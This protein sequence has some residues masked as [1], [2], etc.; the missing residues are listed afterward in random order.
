MK[1]VYLPI[2]LL[3]IGILEA[4]FCLGC[5]A[6]SYFLAD[7][8]VASLFFILFSF[9]GFFCIFGYLNCRITYDETS[10]TAKNIFGIKR[11]YQYTEITGISG[12]IKDIHFYMGKRKVLIDGIAVGSAEFVKF[13]KKRYRVL[14]DGEAIPNQKRKRK[15][16]IFNGNIE[17]PGEFILIYILVSVLD[18]VLLIVFSVWLFAP[19]NAE[20]TTHQEVSFVSYE[21]IDDEWIFSDGSEIVYKFI[22]EIKNMDKILAICDGKTT[23]DLYV[24]EMNDNSAQYLSIRGIYQ[25]EEAIFSFEE[26]TAAIRRET[27]LPVV[28]ILGTL[29]LL[30]GANVAGSIIVGRNPKKYKRWVVELFFKR[31]YVHYD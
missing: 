25:G 7:A 30:W 6:G 21:Q 20:N 14:T 22:Y 24:K 29:S 26:C 1:K 17:N 2:Y 8:Q 15:M 27:G 18:I 10:F 19:V 4:V 28:V 5:A 13:A 9:L 12:N 3:I 11:T 31:S 16:D 23:V